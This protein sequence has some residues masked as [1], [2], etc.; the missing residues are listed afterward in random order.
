MLCLKNQKR[1][2]FGPISRVSWKNA[3]S[4][5][6]IPRILDHAFMHP[7]HMNRSPFVSCAPHSSS[8][9]LSLCLTTA[10]TWCWAILKLFLFSVPPLILKSPYPQLCLP[11]APSMMAPLW[12]L[13]P[14]SHHNFIERKSALWNST[15]QVGLGG[16]GSAACSSLPA[17]NLIQPF[18]VFKAWQK[19]EFTPRS[20]LRL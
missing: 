9:C 2:S 18:E 17:G 1:L 10:S 8:L 19:N 13:K 5:H 12:R 20:L 3:N 11:A 4:A 6:L 15:G 16:P 14:N 7:L